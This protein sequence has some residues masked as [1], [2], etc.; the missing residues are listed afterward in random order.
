[1][2]IYLPPPPSVVFVCRDPAPIDYGIPQYIAEGTFIYRCNE[3]FELVGNEQIKCN[4]NTGRW[5]PL[6]KCRCMEPPTPENATTVQRDDTFIQYTCNENFQM[7]GNANISC[8]E[9]GRWTTSP[10]CTFL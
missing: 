5:D 2:E 4:T 6:P 1:M 7:S 10:N 8:D 9:S 3:R